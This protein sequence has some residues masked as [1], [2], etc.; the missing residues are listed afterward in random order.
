MKLLDL[1]IKD[2]AKKRRRIQQDIA[3]LYVQIKKFEAQKNLTKDQKTVRH[4]N[5]EI[6]IRQALIARLDKKLKAA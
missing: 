6:R 1:K 2:K 3:R 5:K 4:C